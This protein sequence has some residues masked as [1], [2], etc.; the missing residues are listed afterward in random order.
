MKAVNLYAWFDILE[1][2]ILY[3]AESLISE[4]KIIQTVSTP[5]IMSNISDNFTAKIEVKNYG[6]L[7]TA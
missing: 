4:P 1:N 3:P 5:I 7:S 2:L 6:F